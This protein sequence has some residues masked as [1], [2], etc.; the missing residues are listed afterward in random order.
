MP[1]LR[2]AGARGASSGFRRHGMKRILESVSELV[3]I[4]CVG[5]GRT[6]GGGWPAGAYLASYDPAGNNGHGDAAWTAD[7]AGA[8]VFSDMA[9]AAECYR[10]VPANR[11]LR[12]DGKPNRPL[13]MFAI[14]YVPV[15]AP[16]PAPPPAASPPPVSLADELRNMGLM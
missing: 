15:P 13:T 1:P 2:A 4:A 9:A 5:L 11:P 14:T 6:F 10:A 8:L 12:E 16:A 7:P 3:M